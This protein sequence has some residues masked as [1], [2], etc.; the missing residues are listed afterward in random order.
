[1]KPLTLRERRFVAVAILAAMFATLWGLVLDPVIGGYFRLRDDRERLEDQLARNERLAA[2]LE[3][4]KVAADE[5][6]ESAAS[7]AIR[8]TTM[9]LASEILKEQLVAMV[10][11]AGGTAKAISTVDQGVPEHW[12]RVRADLHMSHQQLHDVLRHLAGEVPYVVVDF[13]SVVADRA[14]ASGR[15]EPLEVSLAV[16]APVV[17][18]TDPGGGQANAG[19]GVRGVTRPCRRTGLAIV[20]RGTAR[21]FSSRPGEGKRS[22]SGD[23][24]APGLAANSGQ[25]R[26]FS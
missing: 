18:S 7:F 22:N 15:L 4:W 19:G 11:D 12:I 8:A 21:K 20:R 9:A 23:G 5:Q 24:Q 17:L 26:V 13:L 2:G 10:T 1:M 25:T 3:E 6:A 14:A 16:S